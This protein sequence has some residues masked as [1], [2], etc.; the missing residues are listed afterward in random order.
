MQHQLQFSTDRQRRHTQDP[1]QH[2][3]DASTRQKQGTP[4]ASGGKHSAARSRQPKPTSLPAPT[5]AGMA[6]YQ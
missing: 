5:A 4:L 6:K 1:H 3:P 2:R